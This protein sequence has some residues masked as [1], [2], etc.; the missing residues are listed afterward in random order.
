MILHFPTVTTPEGRR[1]NIMAFRPKSVM[2]MAAEAGMPE[3]QHAEGE[4]GV[5]T[6]TRSEAQHILALTASVAARVLD[7]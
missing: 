4:G 1:E 3:A 6:Y 5:S 2:A 7:T